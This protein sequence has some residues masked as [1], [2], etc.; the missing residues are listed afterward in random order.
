MSH[1]W[2]EPPTGGVKTCTLFKIKAK[3]ESHRAYLMVH[4][5]F[6]VN[7]LYTGQDL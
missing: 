3:C 1:V 2:A 7:P 5:D 4:M 6:K